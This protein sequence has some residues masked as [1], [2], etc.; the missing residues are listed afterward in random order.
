[1]EGA[2]ASLDR[3]SAPVAGALLGAVRGL[4]AGLD[5]AQGPREA[6]AALAAHARLVTH[7][8]RAAE[9]ATRIR[10]SAARHWRP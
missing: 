9:T 5:P 6:A 4:A 2:L 3:V 7:V 10:D 1:M 8:E